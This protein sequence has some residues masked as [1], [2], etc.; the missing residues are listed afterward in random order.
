MFPNEQQ[1]E[2]LNLGIGDREP[3]N[4]PL[5]E[6]VTFDGNTRAFAPG[7]GRL[8]FL[9]K[10]LLPKEPASRIAAIIAIRRPRLRRE[11]DPGHVE[12]FIKNLLR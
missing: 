9:N 8:L 1:Q 10:W 11:P 2:F 5:A 3:Q 4:C 6:S 12:F 7:W